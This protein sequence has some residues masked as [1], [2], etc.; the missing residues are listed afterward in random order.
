MFRLGGKRSWK[1]ARTGPGP[2]TFLKSRTDSDQ[3]QICKKRTN[4]VQDQLNFSN[5]GPYRTNP[6]HVLVS[7]RL[8]FRLRGK[9]SWKVKY[10]IRTES[11]RFWLKIN[12]HEW[13]YTIILQKCTIFNLKEYYPR[14]C[15]FFR[16]KNWNYTTIRAQTKRSD[17]N[18]HKLET[19]LSEL[20]F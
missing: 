20:L 11:I 19:Y 18:P 4:P 14:R 8:M 5:H 16:Q 2:R 6:N 9:R 12:N 17:Q 10:T 3:D 15:R 1:V 7:C 13:K